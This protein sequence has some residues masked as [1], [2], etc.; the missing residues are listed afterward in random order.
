MASLRVTSQLVSV[1]LI[2]ILSQ[3]ALASGSQLARRATQ[4]CH[5][6]AKMRL[7]TPPFENRGLAPGGSGVTQLARRANAEACKVTQLCH[8]LAKMRL[9]TP[10]FENRGLAPGGSGFRNFILRTGN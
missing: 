3:E 10:P 5:W 6:L 4:L 7:K 8:W 1:A 2:G 9:K